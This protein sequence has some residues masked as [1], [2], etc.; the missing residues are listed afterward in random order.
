[1]PNNEKSL[2]DQLRHV[3]YSHIDLEDDV[4]T[5][6]LIDD[7]LDL[8]FPVLSSIQRNVRAAVALRPREVNFTPLNRREHEQAAWM[9]GYNQALR[10]CKAALS[11]PEHVL[12]EASGGP[13]NAS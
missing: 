3:V 6:N 1:M 8:A 5:D 12:S 13:N 10:D 7:I 11:K 9:R 2:R 4:R